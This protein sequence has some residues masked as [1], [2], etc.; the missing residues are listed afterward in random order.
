L[1]RAPRYDLS[2]YIKPIYVTEWSARKVG[3]S[4]EI[5]TCTSKIHVSRVASEPA[6]LE[7]GL[8]SAEVWT[9]W[10]QLWVHREVNLM[11]DMDLDLWNLDKIVVT[12][13]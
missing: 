7:T 9:P 12:L 8:R 10:A 4:T 2:C 1:L 5:Q 3:T 13:N 6:L 11:C